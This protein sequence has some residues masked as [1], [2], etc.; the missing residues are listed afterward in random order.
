[1][2]PKNDDQIPVKDS[3]NTKSKYYA[4]NISSDNLKQY[5][6]RQNSCKPSS[7]RL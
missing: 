4:N 3:S 7:F 2:T 5:F 1:M 6:S